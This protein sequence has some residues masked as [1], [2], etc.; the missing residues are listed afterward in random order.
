MKTS[1][2]WSTM[3]N[4]KVAQTR[5]NCRIQK[6]RNHNWILQKRDFNT[7]KGSDEKGI[8]NGDKQISR[9]GIMLIDLT[10]IYDL[11]AVNNELVCSGKWTSIRTTRIKNPS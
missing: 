9:N 11:T 10:E 4:K 6:Y 5:S 7:K 3:E 8:Q 2:S 1:L